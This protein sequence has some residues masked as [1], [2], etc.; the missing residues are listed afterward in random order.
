MPRV[1]FGGSGALIQ[2]EL[3]CP[4]LHPQQQRA[5]P[6]QPKK[7]RFD[8]DVKSVGLDNLQ[9]TGPIQQ[10]LMR[11]TG[12]PRRLLGSAELRLAVGLQFQPSTR[13]RGALQHRAESTARSNAASTR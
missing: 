12:W 8:G 5:F 6:K 7:A 1:L 3:S 2:V 11:P 9:C 10:T 13:N 4:E